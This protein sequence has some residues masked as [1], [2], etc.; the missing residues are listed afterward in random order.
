MKIY[1]IT[2]VTRKLTGKTLFDEPLG[3]THVAMFNLV[4]ELANRGHEVKVF[5]NSADEEGFYE[6]V[7]YLLTNKIISYCKQNEPDILICTASESVL[8][9]KIKAKKTILWLHND[10]SP[11][12]N[13][14]LPDIASKISGYMAIKADKLVTVSDW[15]KNLIKET[16]KIPDE[17]LITIGNGINKQLFDNNIKKTKNRLI[18]TSAP[19]RGL[20]LLL[21]FFP[22]IKNLFPDTQ[23]HI[24]SSFSTW[25]KSDPFH[26]ELETKIF[27]KTKQEG[28]FLHEPLTNKELAKKLSEN[29]LFL[30]PNHE[31]SETYFHA[32]TFGMAVVEAQFAGLPIVT[33]DRGALGETVENN[34]T[35]FLI[36]ENP[37]SEKYKKTFL[38]K[39]ISLLSDENIWQ[40]YSNNAKEF[41]QKFELKKITD[42]WENLFKTLLTEERVKPTE[43]PLKSNYGEPEVSI[44][45]PS[46]NRASNLVHVLGAL[47]KQTFK[48]FELIIIDDGSTDN[49]KEIVEQF[50][51]KLNIR[52]VYAGKNEGF[53]AAR[54][55]NIGLS[56][57]R[58]NLIVFL[59]SDIVTPSTYLEEHLKIHAK[60]DRILVDSFVYRMKHYDETDLGVDPEIYIKNHRDILNDDIKYEFNVFDRG[61]PL[62]EGYFLDSNSLSIKRKHIIEEGFDASFVGWGHE[63]TELGYRFASQNFGFIFI[64]EHC[65]SYHIYHHISPQKDEETKVNWKRLTEKYALKKCYDPL[66]K[67]TVE[68]LIRINNIQPEKAFLTDIF[69][70]RFE[71]KVGDKIDSHFPLI[72]FD[73]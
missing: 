4:N 73:F 5:C 7:E 41:A 16:F 57:A 65:E 72:N 39:T 23:L 31:S 68:G 17:H 46:Y 47:T 49:T 40:S 64:K 1:F 25:G 71:I 10:Y 19:D 45:M 70:G 38:E 35:G 37:Y 56:R 43:A 55:R 21:D 59:D 9:V 28:V 50:R 44:I 22:D 14:E 12:W 53:R 3:G 15:Q 52:Y 63:D 11:Y 27:E 60:Y 29:Y 54:A 42:T 30:Y 36:S 26:K 48:N 8:K 33:S 20:D 24:Y 66:P 13:H 61:Y 58:G 6:K 62:E 2:S 67:I 69:E 34:K 51:Q 18:Y 32:E